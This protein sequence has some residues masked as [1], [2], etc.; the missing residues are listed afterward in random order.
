MNRQ[1]QILV[2]DDHSKMRRLIRE[3][4][5]ALGYANVLE[6]DDGQSALPILK[7]GGIDLIITDLSMPGLNGIELTRCIRD[8]ARLKAMPVVMISVDSSNEQV[9]R[10]TAAGANC[11]IVKPFTPEVLDQQIAAVLQW[12]AAEEAGQ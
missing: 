1:M 6:A 11:Y 9:E 2:V 4:L 8:D 10:A 7:A 5:L 3:Q 12:A